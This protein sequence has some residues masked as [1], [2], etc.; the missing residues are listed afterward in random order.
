LADFKALIQ[1]I[2]QAV[3]QFNSQIPG[4]QKKM[5]D[6]LLL[7]TKKL[8]TKGD[9]IEIGAA[10]LRLL[11]NVKSKLQRILLNE[12]YIGSVKGYIGNFD[13]VID[14][15][16]KYFRSLESTFQPPQL[17]REIKKQAIESVVN[18]LTENGLN[19]NIVDRIHDILRKATTAGGSYATL[20][21]QLT[22]FITSNQSGE[23]QLLRYTKQITTDALNQFSGQY[24]QLVTADLGFEWYRYSGSNIETS[25]P[26]CLACTDRKFFHISQLPR[27]LK[28]D[29][30]EFREREG[31]INRKTDLPEGMISGTDVSNFMTNRGGYNCGHQWRPLSEELVPRE[32]RLEVYATQE[33]RTWA[34]ING[35]KV[36]EVAV[37]KEER[38][39][40]AAV[41][42]AAAVSAAQLKLKER[43]LSRNEE[44]IAKWKSNDY[45]LH[46]DLLFHLGE[47]ISLEIGGREEAFYSPL[48]KK[49]VIGDHGDRLK[50]AY[51]RETLLAH[52][53]GHAIHNTRKIIH[54]GEVEEGFRKHFD[55]LKS[56]IK[57]KEQEIQDAFWSRYRGADQDTMEQLMVVFDILGSLTRGKFGGG[58][59]VSY[60][61]T[62][63]KPEAEV[64]AHAVSLLKVKNAYEDLTPEMA[65]VIASMREYVS[66]V[67]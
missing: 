10:N 15:Q 9:T 67:L 27:V 57:G 64:F 34:R 17:V 11:S 46:E 49:V 47:E 21:K 25:R 50:S 65:K 19:A 53:L 61:K 23:G 52:E 42:A 40:P 59:T 39:P 3:D 16:N 35:R 1:L 54:L 33:Y 60:Y 14:L 41:P 5:L 29:F 2:T 51:F 38:Q 18:S 44:A 31:K 4:I 28:G 20:T 36:P 56:I 30:D 12:K 48:G 8:N 58:H 66:K 7:L 45:A 62:A 43:I 26:F 24:T 13:K 37:Q 55:S 63:G 32:I 22:D 6:D